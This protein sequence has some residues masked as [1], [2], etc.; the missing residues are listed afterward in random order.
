MDWSKRKNIECQWWKISQESDN[1]SETVW[2]HSATLETWRFFWKRARLFTCGWLRW[3]PPLLHF[4]GANQKLGVWTS[5]QC[6]HLSVVL[7]CSLTRPYSAFLHTA[8]SCAI[9][10]SMKDLPTIYP[11]C[12][13]RGYD[14]SIFQQRSKSVN[15]FS[16]TG[17]GAYAGY[18]RFHQEPWAFQR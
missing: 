13:T 1:Y 5:S 16:R 11:V 7:I 8:E 14:N 12:H 18:H 3:S 9:S 10:I 4:H 17:S 15:D 6:W 2:Q